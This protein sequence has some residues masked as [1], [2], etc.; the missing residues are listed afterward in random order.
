M[1]I[2]FLKI[3][4]V[5]LRCSV[6]HL[7]NSLNSWNHSSSTGHVPEGSA[8]K[9]KIAVQA[10]VANIMQIVIQITQEMN[11]THQQYGT[12]HSKNTQNQGAS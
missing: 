4:F 9:T 5:V 1:P 12:I 3:C 6:E 11:L 8:I 7:V 2:L 10:R